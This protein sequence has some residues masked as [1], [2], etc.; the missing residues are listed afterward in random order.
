MQQ[1]LKFDGPLGAYAPALTT[2]GAKGH[3]VQQASPVAVIFKSEGRGR[4][5]LH[6]RQ[7]S[8]AFLIDDKIRHMAPMNIE[9]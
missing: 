3:V 2:P 6:A 1:M 8:V 9:N 5:V 7:T 4:T